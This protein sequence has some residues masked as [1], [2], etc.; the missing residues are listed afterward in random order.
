MIGQMILKITYDRPACAD[1][2]YCV[3][4][5]GCVLASLWY[6][7]ES[8]VLEDY[9]AIAYL[10]LN[11]MGEGSFRFTGRR[12]VP[13]EAT[14]V[15]A[16]FLRAD[17]LH[18]EELSVPIPPEQK[19]A[20]PEPSVRLTVMSDLHLK[21]TSLQKKA[22]RIRR[23]LRTGAAGSAALLLPGDLTDDGLPG[24]LALLD[25]MLAETVSCPV[26]P[27]AGNH[28]YPA[29]HAADNG[30]RYSEFQSRVLERNGVETASGPSGAY[31]ARIGD[32]EVIGLNCVTP[33][34]RFRLPDEQL[35]WLEARLTDGASW[36]IILC[37]APLLAHNPQRQAGDPPYL[38]QD[39]RL[40]SL[41]D[42]HERILFLSGHTHFSPNDANGCAEYDEARSILYLN[43][44]S[45]C[46]TTSRWS[47]D[48]V[49]PGEWCD[50]VYAEVT[51]SDN[52][53]G[54]VFR[55]AESGKKIAR[56]I[57]QF[58]ASSMK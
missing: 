19:S 50:G 53:C 2:L 8:G 45:I 4:A 20:W 36:H 22:F 11:A 47:D 18:T 29:S 56:G 15:V 39:K 28:D 30:L 26:F 41:L 40:A 43:D 6:G 54:I 51:L 1:G 46:P 34:R 24:Q 35:E 13:S 12:S 16:R 10:P 49:V 31:A 37:H 21:E 33:E 3:R 57:Y 14:H 9:T 42:A 48:A 58:E 52:G 27:A 55:S 44:G 32:V 25:R 23:A 17:A 7:G 38:S 5:K